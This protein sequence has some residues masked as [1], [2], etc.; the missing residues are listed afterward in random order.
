[1]ITGRD[2]MTTN[3]KRWVCVMPHSSFNEQRVTIFSCVLNS[4]K[5]LQVNIQI[6]RI[7]TW[8]QEALTENLSVKLEIQVIRKRLQILDKN[9]E[10]VFNYSDKLI[11]KQVNPKPGKPLGFKRKS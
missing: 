10:L 6:V 11:E 3:L 9:I 7:F 5:A 8:T 2:F 1:M 4:P